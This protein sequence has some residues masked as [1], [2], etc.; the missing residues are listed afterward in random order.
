MTKITLMYKPI[1]LGLFLA[2]GLL[3]FAA[4]AQVVPAKEKAAN[5]KE[6][7]ASPL[8]FLKTDSVNVPLS[9]AA[10]QVMDKEWIESITV[11]KDKNAVDQFGPE[12][13]DGVI[14]I[15]IKPAQE[16]TFLQTLK[17][18]KYTAAAE[19]NIRL[20]GGEG[21]TMAD[22]LYFIQTKAG[23]VA[24]SKEA[25]SSLNPEWIKSINVLKGAEAEK[26]FKKQ[27]EN[28]V[29]LITLAAEKEQHVLNQL[30]NKN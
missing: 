22:P 1:V 15:E 12:G 6:A 19:K 24:V 7:K 3:P 18:P 29:I 26:R 2:A 27:G 11:L 5:V 21:K 17:D 14:L 10:I 30:R 28:G 20:D 9:A 8:Y 16:R 23:E 25:I 13:K 4:E